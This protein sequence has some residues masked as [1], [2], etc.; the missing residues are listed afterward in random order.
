M[1]D[2]ETLYSSDAF[3]LIDAARA[4][5]IEGDDAATLNQRLRAA[6]HAPE[7][8]RHVLLQ[9]ELQL[10]G[11]RKFGDDAAHLAFTRSGLEQA[12]RAWIAEYH[13]KRMRSSGAKSI[14]DL[15][16]GIGA[17][18]RAF[19][20]AGLRVR[21]V[22][23]DSATARIA[24]FNLRQ[25]EH[26]VAEQGLAEEFD[27]D[28]VDAA[29]LDP[30]RRTSRGRTPNPADWSPSLDFA[31]DLAE[32]MPLGVKLGPAISHELLPEEA[33]WQWVGEGTETLEACV[34]AGGAER[35]PGLRSALLRRNGETHEMTST[36]PLPNPVSGLLGAFLY[37]P[38][39]TVIRAGLLSHLAE[40]LHARLLSDGIAYL[41]SDTLIEHPFATAFRVL[42]EQPLKPKVLAARM[43]ALDIGKLEIKQRGTGIDPNDF[44][45]RLKLRGSGSAVLVLTRLQG[46]HRAVIA[47]RT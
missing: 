10:T 42:E 43:R 6:G 25:F 8:V 17:D 21:A 38:H 28:A 45:K 15:G 36:I 30:A 13:S 26:A 12:T 33:E 41:T 34:Y 3:A 37:E 20:A 9:A 46:D 7:L 22:D 32:K 24:A 31:F 39:G 1:A 40:A 47:L 14:A 4:S 11:V 35:E 23:G 19:A 18:A 2:P 16:C 44:R 27:T 29:W 5:L